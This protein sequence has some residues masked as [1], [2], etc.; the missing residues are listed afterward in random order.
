MTVEDKD[1][2]N[3]LDGLTIMEYRVVAW[4][5]SPEPEALATSVALALRVEFRS[6]QVADLVMRLKNPG[7]VDTM[8]ESLQ[9]MKRY[10][11]PHAS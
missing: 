10:V 6:G 5:P 4:T 7:A 3:L 2:G 8:I 9:K 11:W 1:C